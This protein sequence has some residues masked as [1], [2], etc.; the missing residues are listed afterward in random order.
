MSQ[1]QK[2]KK[3]YAVRRGLQL[4][5]FNEWS[6][7]EFSITGISNPEYKTFPDQRL[8]ELWYAGKPIELV[9]TT[10]LIS[11][12]NKDGSKKDEKYQLCWSAHGWTGKR[13]QSGR[14]WLLNASSS[15][16]KKS[17]A[18]KVS[19]NDLALLTIIKKQY[20]DESLKIQFVYIGKIFGAKK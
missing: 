8:A 17:G 9:I 1:T 20:S 7:V 11:K 6:E 19:I 18:S 12:L 13:N 2:I 16:I 14:D 4:G 5:I 3:W 15:I 10:T